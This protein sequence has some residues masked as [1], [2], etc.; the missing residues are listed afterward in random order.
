VS[1][2]QRPARQ[3]GTLVQGTTDPA[4]RAELARGELRKKIPA[5]K[6]ALEGRF[7]YLHSVWIGAILADLDF[8]DEQI[9]SLS[10]AIGEQIALSSRRLSCGARFPACSG[11]RPR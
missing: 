4:I 8:L 10:E 1:V 2:G 11:A 5:L 6:Q 3:A 7:D 9:A